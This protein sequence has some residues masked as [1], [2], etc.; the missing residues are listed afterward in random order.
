MDRQNL[1]I[2]LSVKGEIKLRNRPFQWSKLTHNSSLIK[3]DWLDCLIV[4]ALLS[5]GIFLLRSRTAEL[6]NCYLAIWLIEIWRIC[7]S[8]K[9]VNEQNTP[10]RRQG[11]FI[12]CVLFKYPCYC[13]C[14]QLILR[15]NPIV[16]SSASF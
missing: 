4:K 1:D 8:R 13:T 15:F 3:M 10:I 14:V 11:F 12:C 2:M 16:R 5:L 6:Q 7:H 9:I